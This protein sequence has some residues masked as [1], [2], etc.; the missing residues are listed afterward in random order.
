MEGI[1]GCQRP[2]SA[3][4]WPGDVTTPPSLIS[5]TGERGGRGERTM[6]RPP[7]DSRTMGCTAALRRATI[8][9]TQ[10]TLHPTW[11]TPSTNHA[12]RGYLRSLRRSRPAPALA[13]LRSSAGSNHHCRRPSLGGTTPSTHRSSASSRTPLFVAICPDPAAAAH[14]AVRGTPLGCGGEMGTA[15]GGHQV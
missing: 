13:R 9:S 3:L 15:G 8:N 10:S 4:D 6:P 5:R 2:G 12:A 11:S 1:F 14:G 7:F